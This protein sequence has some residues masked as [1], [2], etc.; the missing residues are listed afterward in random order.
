MNAKTASVLAML[1]CFSVMVGI[2]AHSASAATAM[3]ARSNANC[4]YTVKSGDWLSKLTPNWQAV[5]RANGIAN[6]NRIY[7]G[8]HIDLCSSAVGAS[9]APPVSAAAAPHI[10]GV[11]VSYTRG[12]PCMSSVMWPNGPTAQWMVPVSCYGG[13]YNNGLGGDCFTWV[14][15]LHPDLWRLTYHAWPVV[16][17]VAHFAPGVDG[18]SPVGH[19]AE[20]VSIRDGWMLISEAAMFWRGG[21]D[22]RTSYRYVPIGPGIAFLY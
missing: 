11:M 13:V 4:W 18:A 7:P 12:E 2:S 17:A 22:G 5:A 8:Q 19:Y 16:G 14:A 9:N 15:Y 20:V 10:N 1:V 3:P 6:P 21:G